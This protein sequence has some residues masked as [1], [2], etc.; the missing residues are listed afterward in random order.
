MTAYKP[1]VKRNPP[2]PNTPVIIV[3]NSNAASPNTN[4]IKT[5]IFFYYFTINELANLSNS[6]FDSSFD[7]YAVI[8]W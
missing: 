7:S 6:N 2:M 3:I 5:R 4:L 8:N 1:N